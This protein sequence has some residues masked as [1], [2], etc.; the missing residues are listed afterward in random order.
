[1]NLQTCRRH[2]GPRFL[3]TCPGCAQELYDI[4]AANRA[5]ALA[6]RDAHARR[7]RLA[8]GLPNYPLPVA[9]AGETAT[10]LCIWDVKTLA[11]LY[12][13]L[14][15]TV[16]SRQIERTYSDDSTETVTEITVT[17]DLPGIGT[18]ELF[19]DWEPEHGG[20]ELA[21]MRA[22]NAQTLAV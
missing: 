13:R 3:R 20:T 18:V 12:D 8:L 10:R 21:V 9:S 22:L 5:K 2:P 1:M 19:T 16:T 6:N 4:E 14:G 7:V 17:V 11:P 15:G